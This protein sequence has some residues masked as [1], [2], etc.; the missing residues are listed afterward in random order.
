MQLGVDRRA[1][2]ALSGISWVSELVSALSG[3]VVGLISGWVFERRAG[4]A[5]R[6]EN[7]ALRRELHQLREG[8]Y[9]VGGGGPEVSRQ[10]RSFQ[11]L[12]QDLEE[13]ARAHQDF[14]RRVGRQD[15]MMHFFSGGLTAAQIEASLEELARSGRVRLSENWIEVL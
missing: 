13:W 3:L 6:A 7:E 2:W 1:E 4:K 10:N 11:D 8:I 5:A 12:S 15:L 14:S 9:S